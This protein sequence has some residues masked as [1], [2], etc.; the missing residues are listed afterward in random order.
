MFPCAM[1][2]TKQITTLSPN[3]WITF[4]KIPLPDQSFQRRIL[5]ILY[6]IE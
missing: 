4:R 2:S 1:D 3:K 6:S 5:F